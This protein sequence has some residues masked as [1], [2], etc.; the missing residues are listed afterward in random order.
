MSAPSQ[1]VFRTLTLLFAILLGA[2]CIWLL[3]AQIS[4]P[5]IHRLPTDAA[6]AAVASQRRGAAATAATIGAIRG[7]LWAES[8]F[9][10]SDLLFDKTASAANA[11]T[12]QNL[13]RGR[14]SLERA[15]EDAPITPAAWLLLAGFAL[16][17][18]SAAFD[19]TEILKMSYYTGPSDQDLLPLRLRMAVHSETLNDVEMRQFIARDLRL[20]I[21]RQQ[22]SEITQTY[23]AASPA[24]KRLIEQIVKDID[25]SFLSSLSSDARGHFLP[26]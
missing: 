26:D 23:S 9:T 7:D 18:P 19:A 5:G 21:T 4:R 11:D 12:S 6:D 22:K 25:P 2:Q 17:Y 15:V 14:V 16:R 20:L 13:A 8:A 10:Y 1:F 3:V 24:G